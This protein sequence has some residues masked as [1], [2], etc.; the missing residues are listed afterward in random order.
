MQ[1]ERLWYHSGA[2]TTEFPALLLRGCLFPF[3]MSGT[4]RSVA[5]ILQ[6]ALLAV[7]TFTPLMTTRQTAAESHEVHGQQTSGPLDVAM[8]D[9]NPQRSRVW[10]AR[11]VDQ[12]PQQ[13]LWKSEKLFT[14]RD[15]NAI[16]A[17]SGPIS[18]WLDMPTDQIFTIPVIS[19]GI[20]FFVFSTR[21]NSYLYA[22]DLSTGK[23][24]VTLKFASNILSAPASVGR[25]VFVGASSCQVHAYDLD[26]RAE[27][28]SYEDKKC[29]FAALPPI[30]DDDVVYMAGQGLGLFAF[31]VQTGEV[32]WSLK[33]KAWIDGPA[34]MNDDLIVTTGDGLL[35]ALNKKT[36][37]KKWEAKID[38]EASSPA[39]LD[40]VIFLLRPSR[41]IRAYALNDG[42]LKWKAK[43][44][45]G[46]ATRLV[47]FKDL[48]IYGAFEDSLIA[49]DAGTGLQKWIF[50]TKLPCFNP[51]V[52]GGTLFA[53]CSDRQLYAIDPFT[54]QE[55]WRRD[56]KKAT[57]PPPTF[58]NGIMYTLGSDG[59]MYA[60]K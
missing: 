45:G 17:E 30:I 21:D 53:V 10:A 57:P 2:A 46:A 12:I 55:K 25:T 1:G 20:A 4:I 43:V 22:I 7:M 52:A 23:A 47:L 28:W 56:N 26:A 42:A 48:A 32:V 35:I 40:D 37:A 50:K 15:L 51:V 60:M 8:A 18:M 54:G 14:L 6:F 58:A 49:L 36:G 13:V 27:K 34:I 39:I 16:R 24:V 19:N 41:E 44:H 9:A 59:L 33:T 3:D 38:G 29:S 5:I 11:A 31:R